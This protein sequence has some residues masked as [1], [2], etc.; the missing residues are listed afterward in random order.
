MIFAQEILK[1]SN[2]VI[3]FLRAGLPGI[4]FLPPVS[5]PLNAARLPD[6][7]PELRKL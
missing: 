5:K 7:D 1:I 3:N 6:P 4:F 2:A